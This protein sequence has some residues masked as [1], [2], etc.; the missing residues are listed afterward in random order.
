MKQVVSICVLSAVSFIAMG[1]QSS[2]DHDADVQAIKATESQ[3]NQAWAS[4]DA[5]KVM[6]FY[7]DD[8]VVMVAGEPASVGKPAI[9]AAMTPMIADPA[10]DLKFE[11]KRVEVSKSGDMG[12]TQGT[13]TM[14][15]MDPQTKQV[16]H[17]H[18]TYVTTYRKQADGTWKA[19][20]DVPTSEVPP[21]P[22]P[23]AMTESH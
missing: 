12:Y 5:N 9:A 4:K 2:S 14:A 10:T 22:A 7:A 23:V 6:S 1:C 19:V 3:W 16:M 13:Y 17:D 18:G 8:A 20:M 21:S 11:A 15:V